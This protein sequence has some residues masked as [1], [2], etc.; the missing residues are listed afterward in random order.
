MA[1]LQKC[2]RVISTGRKTHK[3]RDVVPSIGVILKVTNLSILLQ[4][5]VC[6]CEVSMQMPAICCLHNTIA[7]RLSPDSFRT[8]LTMHQGPIW[9]DLHVHWL[10]QGWFHLGGKRDEVPEG[11]EPFR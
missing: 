8:F 5:E 10:G 1:D 7:E 6:S 11:K 2:W 4:E 3:V 9:S